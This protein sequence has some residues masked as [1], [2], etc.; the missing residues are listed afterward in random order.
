MEPTTSPAR[1]V[2][3]RDYLSVLRRYRI[4]IVAI[5]AVGALAGLLAAKGQ[6]PTYRATASVSFQDPAQDLT[7]AGLS[8]GLVQPPATLAAANAETLTRPQ[9]MAAVRRTLKTPESIASLSAAVSG[10]VSTAGLLQIT[11]SS[12]TPAFAAQLANATARSVVGQ[13]NA[14]TRAS[15]AMAASDVRSRIADIR[16][17]SGTPGASARLLV[18]EDELARLDPLSRFAQSAQVAQAAQPPGSPS[19]PNTLRST[20][21]GLALGLALAI[22]VAFFTDSLDRRLRTARDVESGFAFPI[23]GHVRNRALGSVVRADG[24]A[25]ADHQLDIDAFR[26]LRRNLESL[27]PDAPPRSIIVTSAIS[28]EGKSTVAA[29]LAFA[30][31]SAGRRTLLVDCDLRRPAI[32]E[33]LGME[34]SPG[35]SDFLAGEATPQQILR[36]IPFRASLSL[37]GASANGALGTAADNLLVAIP[38]G[39]PTSHTAELL[40]SRRFKEFMAQVVQTYDVVVIDSAPILPV[41]DTL[42]MLPHVEGAVICARESK[43]TRDEA[44]AVRMAVARFTQLSVGV[45]VTGIKPSRSDDAVYAGAY[46]YG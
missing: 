18:F 30:I 8:P 4:A 29:S 23:V 36:P 37:N 14:Q 28:E 11:G 19:S 24:K 9:V 32:A 45:V 27:R 12:S 17:T 2:T 25:G 22:A 10:Q 5:A 21:I 42:E 7:L 46:S 6:T 41:S 1:Y 43:T 38:A 31:A 13:D 40:G 35:I 15:F 44:L 34:R 20:L 33:R 3:L 16:A 26:I 39:S